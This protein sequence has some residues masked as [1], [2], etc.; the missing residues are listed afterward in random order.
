MQDSNEPAN[1]EDE[2]D[3]NP[4]GEIVRPARFGIGARASILTGM[5]LGSAAFAAVVAS[6]PATTV[7]GPS[8]S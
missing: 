5:V 1:T 3:E 4:A 8:P 2:L 7:S 6:F